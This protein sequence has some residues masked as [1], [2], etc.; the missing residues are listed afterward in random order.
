MCVEELR[1]REGNG[2]VVLVG[3]GCVPEIKSCP[4]LFASLPPLLP[5]GPLEPEQTL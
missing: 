5:P 1:K 2:K 4:F 3:G